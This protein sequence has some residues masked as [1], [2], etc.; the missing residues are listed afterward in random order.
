[1]L[2]FLNRR[3][4][5]ADL[6]PYPVA[7]ARELLKQNKIEQLYRMKRGDDRLAYRTS[8]MAPSTIQRGQGGSQPRSYVHLLYVRRADY[9]KAR[10][11]LTQEGIL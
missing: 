7:Q 6:D 3:Q 8:Y 10:A 1:M 11:L 2:C 5:L 9:K 4:L